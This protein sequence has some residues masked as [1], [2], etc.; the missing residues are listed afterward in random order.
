MIGLVAAL[1]LLV[2][3]AMVPSPPSAFDSP[4]AHMPLRPDNPWDPVHSM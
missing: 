4:A 1:G 2:Y 3:G